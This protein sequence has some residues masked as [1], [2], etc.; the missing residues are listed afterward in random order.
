MH[1]TQVLDGASF[2]WRHAERFPSVLVP[3]LGVVEDSVA[4]ASTAFQISSMTPTSIEPD[5]CSR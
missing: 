4:S 1:S 3:V 5:S 2:L